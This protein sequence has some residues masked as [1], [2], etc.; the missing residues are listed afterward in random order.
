MGLLPAAGST[1]PRFNEAT[2]TG[3]A[4]DCKTTT[5]SDKGCRQLTAGRTFFLLLWF[6]YF[7]L[8]LFF[9]F[10]LGEGEEGGESVFGNFSLGEGGGGIFE[11]VMGRE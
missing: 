6:F 5:T 2:Q 1:G 9:G 4:R 10:T 3:E 8:F 11:D 7:F